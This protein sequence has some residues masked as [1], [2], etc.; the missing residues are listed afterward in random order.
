M[1]DEREKARE[2]ALAVLE[3]K[4]GDLVM[5]LRAHAGVQIDVISSGIKTLDAMLGIGGIPRGRIFQISGN[6]N[7]GKSTLALLFSAQVLKNGGSPVYIETESKINPYWLRSLFGH[8]GQDYTEMTMIREQICENAFDIA[9]RLC[10][11]VDSIV[12]DS[13][14]GMVTKADAS[15]PAGDSMPAAMARKLSVVLPQL[16][17]AYWAATP[18]PAIVFTNQLTTRFPQYGI[19]LPPHER[20]GKRL[21]FLSTYI[22]RLSK[23]LSK[24]R[25]Q[26][27]KAKFQKNQLALGNWST[28]CQWTI[29]P[30]KG[31]DHVE[32]TIRAG[33]AV[34]VLAGTSHI[35]WRKD[36]P[37]G[38]SLPMTKCIKHLTEDPD[39][40]Y[41]E[42]E[43]QVDAALEDIR[44]QARNG[45]LMDG[46]PLDVA[47]PDTADDEE[48]FDATDEGE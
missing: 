19:S 38:F 10:P 20:G 22:L 26:V 35:Q 46:P 48:E 6:P 37:G 43:A 32:D 28:E 33:K 1:T 23:G 21:A 16:Q 15:A 45:T 4:Y 41:D 39:G 5:N 18:I 3:K 2:K 8:W 9:I 42:I 7:V 36:E 47:E 17:A 14:G 29:L 12:M 11:H 25:G 27:V 24:G 31:I 34:G 40:V 30:G 44:A 13:I